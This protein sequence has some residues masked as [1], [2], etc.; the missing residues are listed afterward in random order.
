MF[1]YMLNE[2]NQTGQSIEFTKAS[3]I[4]LIFIFFLNMIRVIN[5]Q[6]RTSDALSAY[7]ELHFPTEA[8]LL[9]DEVNWTCLV[10][11]CYYSAD[12]L[13]NHSSSWQNIIICFK[14]IIRGPFKKRRRY[15]LCIFIP[16]KNVLC[17]KSLT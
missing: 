14:K 1:Y 2:I 10:E 3:H 9:E 16:F 15:I 7:W 11:S 5:S 8:L 17:F 4:M 6:S 13:M 12:S